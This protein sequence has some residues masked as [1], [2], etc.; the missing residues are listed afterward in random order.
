M[1]ALAT[2][3]RYSYAWI[4]PSVLDHVGPLWKS[5]IQAVLIR[6]ALRSARAR[7][8]RQIKAGHN[9]RMGE[10]GGLPRHSKKHIGESPSNQAA[11]AGGCRAMKGSSHVCVI[12]P[13][14][15]EDPIRPTHHTG[16]AHITLVH[17][18]EGQKRRM[19][20]GRCVCIRASLFSQCVH[21]EDGSGTLN[22]R[23]SVD[24]DRWPTLATKTKRM[25]KANCSAPAVNRVRSRRMI[26]CGVQYAPVQ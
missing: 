8:A 16:V 5:E 15:D 17:S 22:L 20:A 2:Q 25:S 12:P 11:V 21:R 14:L 24:V 6:I 3:C 18:L 9:I 1:A 23:R 19:T 26:G 7:M 4:T 13:Q 10:A